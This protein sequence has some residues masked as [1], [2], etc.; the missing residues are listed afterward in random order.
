M[1]GNGFLSCHFLYS[2]T[3]E[4]FNKKD[5]LSTPK[6]KYSEEIVQ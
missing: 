4:T 1:I 6:P 2:G 5:N 3:I